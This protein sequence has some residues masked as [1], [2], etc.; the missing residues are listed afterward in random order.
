MSAAPEEDVPAYRLYNSKEAAERARPGLGA[1]VFRQLARSGEVEYT[2]VG[3]LIF[4]TDPQIAAA[5]AYLAALGVSKQAKKQPAPRQS[6]TAASPRAPRDRAP[7]VARPGRRYLSA[8]A[9]GSG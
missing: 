7:L 2:P 5:V 4:W 6:R 9:N 8:A 3:R 1:R